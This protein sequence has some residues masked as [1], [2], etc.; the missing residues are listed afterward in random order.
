MKPTNRHAR[1]YGA[2]LVGAVV[3]QLL[4]LAVPQ[5]LAATFDAAGSA[6]GEAVHIKTATFDPVSG[7]ASL[8]ADV[9]VSK[10]VAA[11]DSGGIGTGDLVADSSGLGLGV[12]VPSYLSA[13]FSLADR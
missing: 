6:T 5:A 12:D 4:F 3:A 1:R 11:T 9:D 10:G 8:A 2:L 7:V 13:R